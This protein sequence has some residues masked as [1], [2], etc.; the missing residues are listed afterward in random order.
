MKLN[1]ALFFDRDGIINKL[2]ENRPPWKFSE[3]EIYEGIKDIIEFS[4]A[5]GYLPI[6]ITNQPD[7]GRGKLT[8]ELLH[9]IN[10]NI[11]KEVKIKHFY[12][13]DHPYD[14]MCEC[15]KPK[16]GML[17]MAAK[18]NSINLI[19]SFMIG[20][21]L[22][23]IEA[24]KLAGCKTLSVSKDNLGADFRIENHNQLKSLLNEIL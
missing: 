10:K 19:E 11:C 1:K 7:A 15:R 20:D 6:V 13:C 5:S 3:I 4:K 17:L 24:G 16:P 23:D 8:Y 2:V 22:K 9:R 12:V 21:R 18:E 14:G